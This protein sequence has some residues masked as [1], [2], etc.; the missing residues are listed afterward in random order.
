MTVS[1]TFM[2]CWRETVLLCG[3]DVL[4]AIFVQVVRTCSTSEKEYRGEFDCDE[5]KR[6][7]RPYIAALLTVRTQFSIIARAYHRWERQPSMS[8]RVSF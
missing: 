6:D 4:Q 8:S 1:N 3:H 5:P 2:R 7:A